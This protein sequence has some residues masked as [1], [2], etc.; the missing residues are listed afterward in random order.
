MV[1]LSLCAT[2]LS[3]QHVSFHA[4]ATL[5]I[6]SQHQFTPRTI[7]IVLGTVVNNQGDA[8]SSTSGVFTAPF[9]GFYCFMASTEA[10]ATHKHADMFLMVDNINVDGVNLYYDTTREAGSVHAVVHLL[11]GQ[12]VW[13]KGHGDSVYW[14]RA[15]AFSGFLISPDP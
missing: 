2:A 11:K 15:T 6:S 14:V 12:M 4:R 7:T 8:Y 1:V 3:Q 5:N 10:A 13:L 9:N